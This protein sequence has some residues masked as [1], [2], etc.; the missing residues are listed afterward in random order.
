MMATLCLRLV[1]TALAMPAGNFL[2]YSAVRDGR[3]AN[4]WVWGIDRIAGLNHQRKSLAC[5]LVDAR[6]HKRELLIPDTLGVDFLSAESK[7]RFMSPI[8]IFDME[9]LAEIGYKSNCTY[10]TKNLPHSREISW[11]GSSGSSTLIQDEE[12]KYVARAFPPPSGKC[13]KSCDCCYMSV[14]ERARPGT[15]LRMQYDQLYGKLRDGSYAPPIIIEAKE[16]ML[17]LLGNFSAIHIR[18]GDKIRLD[19]FR[20]DTVNRPPLALSTDT[21]AGTPGSSSRIPATNSVPRNLPCF[22]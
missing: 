7:G 12:A 13:S 10:R 8:H 4:G 11:G 1:S 2:I 16:R 3:A 22:P 18:R 5:A 19:P 14:C 6:L 20:G 21:N 17:K 15:E 9:A